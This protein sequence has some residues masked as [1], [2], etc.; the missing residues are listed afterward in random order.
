MTLHLVGLGLGSK[1]YLTLK[2]LEVMEGADELLLDTYTGWV[3]PELLGWLRQRFGG[4]LRRASRKEL[5]DGAPDVARAAGEREVAVLVPGDPLVAT[6]HISLLLEA[7]RQGIP[8]TVTYGVSAYSAAASASGLQAYK[9]GRATTLPKSGAGAETCYRVIAE[10]MERGL[11][12]LVLLDTADGGLE[13]QEALQML[14]EVEEELGRGVLRGE[15]LTIVL[16]RLGAEE[17]LVWVGE[18]REA[19]ERRYPPPPHMLV[20]PGELHFAESE[21]LVRLLGAQSHVVE[22]H[23]PARYEASRVRSYLEK[24]GRAFKTMRKLSEEPGVERVLEVAESYLEDAGNFL[25]RGELFNS[26]GAIAYCEGL[27]DAL[28]MM[29][30]VSFE[31]G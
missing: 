1:S 18:A 30:K 23:R 14:M 9:F 22:G 6:T 3:A 4:R 7:E 29:G 25:E 19:A 24:A 5:E 8:Y 12:T 20:F 16:V 26:L 15:R 10:N 28:R 11:H 13:A 21:A 27:L 31:W 2:A 17:E